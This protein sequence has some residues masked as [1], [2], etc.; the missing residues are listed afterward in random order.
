MIRSS[1][2]GTDEAFCAIQGF[3]GAT[4]VNAS[5]G[6]VVYSPLNAAVGLAGFAFVEKLVSKVSDQVV[7]GFSAF[8]GP[9]PIGTKNVVSYGVAT[10]TT[11]KIMQIAGLILSVP[12]AVTTFGLACLSLLAIGCIKKAIEYTF[13]PIDIEAHLKSTSFANQMIH[14][15]HENEMYDIRLI[16]NPERK[17]ITFSPAGMGK[18]SCKDTYVLASNNAIPEAFLDKYESLKG[19]S[20]FTAKINSAL[21]LDYTNS[22]SIK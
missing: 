8:F 10:L 9:I 19:A 1:Y 15:E 18:I 13:K 20:V 4:L 7:P 21:A 5:K 22:P 6:L 3:V 12:Q 17:T 14:F 16:C 11:F 2:L